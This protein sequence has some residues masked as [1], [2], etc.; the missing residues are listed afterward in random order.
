MQQTAQLTLSVQPMAAQNGREGERHGRQCR[1][2]AE[3]AEWSPELRLPQIILF[4]EF[5]Q[6]RAVL[7][8]LEFQE[9]LHL[10]LEGAGS[11][12]CALRTSLVSHVSARA[13]DVLTGEG[14]EKR[15]MGGGAREKMECLMVVVVV[16]MAGFRK[17]P[18]L[19]ALQASHLFFSRPLHHPPEP[20][21]IGNLSQ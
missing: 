9:I 11:H 18:S 4:S 13:S 16:K 2:E 1:E 12:H 14:Q 17:G 19:Q 5:A 10:S 15:R 8:S 7:A 20:A 6:V 21:S 3:Q